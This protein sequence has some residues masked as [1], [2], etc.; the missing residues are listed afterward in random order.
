MTVDIIGSC[1]QKLKSCL[2][3]E[4]KFRVRLFAF[5][6]QFLKPQRSIKELVFDRELQE[7]KRGF[8]HFSKP[9]LPRWLILSKHAVKG[10]SEPFTAV[11]K[12]KMPPQERFTL[13]NEKSTLPG[14]HS[15]RGALKLCKNCSNL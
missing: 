9:F 11:L 8:F 10:A 4:E 1:K 3:S 6:F 13:R 14:A 12:S 5:C 7:G 15:N 2:L